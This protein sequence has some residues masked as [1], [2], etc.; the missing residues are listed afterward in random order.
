VR[1]GFS[2][3]LEL[4]ILVDKD[5]VDP[6]AGRVVP[7]LWALRDAQGMPIGDLQTFVGLTSAPA[8]CDGSGAGAREDAAAHNDAPLFYDAGAGQFAFKWLTDASWAGTCRQIQLRL[9]D[10]AVHT[11]V[12]RFR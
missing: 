10:G 8:A 4:P 12:M 1:Y 2:G 9:S 6:R 3:F 5:P 11:A 7:V